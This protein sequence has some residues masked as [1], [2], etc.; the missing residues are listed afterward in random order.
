MVEATGTVC[1]R[2]DAVLPAAGI[3]LA[4]LSWLVQLILLTVH[5]NLWQTSPIA[6]SVN[7]LQHRHNALGEVRAAG[8]WVLELVALRR[9]AIVIK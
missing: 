8:R 5:D 9:E 3:V 7:P 1:L 4:A 6:R 2:L